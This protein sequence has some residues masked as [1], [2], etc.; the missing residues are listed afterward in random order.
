MSIK[1]HSNENFL[2]NNKLTFGNASDLQI[3]HDASNS[4]IY[5]GGTGNLY[6]KNETDD[7]D[8]ILQC[9]DGSGGVTAY[10]TLDG[11][12]GYTTVQKNMR[13]ANSVEIEL[14]TN[15]NLTLEHNGTN[16]FITEANGDLYIKNTANDKDIIFQCDDGSG[17]TTTYFS[18]DGSVG[19]GSTVHTVFPDNSKAV[20]GTGLDLS[21]IHI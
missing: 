1:H 14:G 15:G 16:G 13:F 19:G 8:V 2:D 17:G 6:I 12:A 18:L 3:F 20:F 7:K 11:S 5:H 9:D 21:L 4:Y 10:L